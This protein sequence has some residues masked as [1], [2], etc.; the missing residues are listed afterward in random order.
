M[1][2]IARSY[3]CRVFHVSEI[4]SR[5]SGLREALRGDPLVLANTTANCFQHLF[6]EKNSAFFAA[7]EDSALFRELLLSLI[8]I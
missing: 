7:T 8:H 4:E 6:D 5:E 2:E 3:R 1:L